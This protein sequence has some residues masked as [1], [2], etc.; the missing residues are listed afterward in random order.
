MVV[1]QGI[2]GRHVD[3]EINAAA[4]RIARW[5]RGGGARRPGGSRRSKTVASWQLSVAVGGAW[6]FH[7]GRTGLYRKS[8]L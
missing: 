5:S 2:R 1:G 6:V 8:Y 4:P 3:V 7:L